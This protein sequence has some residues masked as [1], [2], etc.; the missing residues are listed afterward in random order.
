[1][2]TKVVAGTVVANQSH[3]REIEDTQ[4]L[5]SINGIENNACGV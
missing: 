1:M 3:T 4:E 5:L 2:N